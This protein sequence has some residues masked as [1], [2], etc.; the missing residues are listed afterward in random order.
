MHTTASRRTRIQAEFSYCK[1]GN[2]YFSKLPNLN[3]GPIRRP[4]NC[5]SFPPKLDLKRASILLWKELTGG[6]EE[7]RT[8]VRAAIINNTNKEVAY[9]QDYLRI[10]DIIHTTFVRYKQR[11]RPTDA[12]QKSCLPSVVH[13]QLQSSLRV[14]EHAGG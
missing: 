12:S 3:N 4:C 10:P 13:N 14:D 2:K 11:Q 1:I 9:L 6:L 8:C 7:I 5:K